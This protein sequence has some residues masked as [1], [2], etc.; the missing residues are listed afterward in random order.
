[1]NRFAHSLATVFLTLLAPAWAA[2]QSDPAAALLA[3]GEYVLKISGCVHCHTTDDGARLAGG[4][5]LETP[6]GTFFTPN[7]TPHESAGI[8]SW[9]AEQ[10]HAALA[11]GVAPD[12]SHYYPAFPYTSYTKMRR[13]DVEALYAYLMSVPASDTPNREHDLAWYLQWRFA[14]QVWKWLFFV[15][16]EFEARAELD[17]LLNRGAYI[18]EALAHCQECHTPR[19]MAGALRTDLAYAGNPDGPEDEL[20]PNITPDRQTGIGDWSRESLSVFLR[21]G[22]LPNGEYTAGSMDPVIQGIGQLTPEDRD[23]LIDY[24]RSLAPIE[25]Q[26]NQ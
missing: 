11:H 21:F 5:G 10:F 17:E 16:G 1:M 15:P 20:V 25:N 6:F 4:R 23:A 24:L 22:E 12:G 13:E 2:A 8:G 9:N 18:A 26:V 7:I 14:A 3:R 19:N